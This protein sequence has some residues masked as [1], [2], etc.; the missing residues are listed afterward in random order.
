MLPSWQWKGTSGCY[1]DKW[2]TVQTAG[3]LKYF[4]S[5]E[6]ISVKLFWIIP[7]FTVTNWQ[8]SSFFASNN[9]HAILSFLIYITVLHSIVS[10]TTTFHNKQSIIFPVSV[11]WMDTNERNSDTGR[12]REDSGA[13]EG[14]TV[15]LI[16]RWL[17]VQFQIIQNLVLLFWFIKYDTQNMRL[18]NTAIKWI[19]ILYQYNIKIYFSNKNSTITLW[20]GLSCRNHAPA[21]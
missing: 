8:C 3:Q 7:N 16:D 2:R 21:H 9:C 12:V 1:N 5:Q 17:T 19:Y 15:T 6:L 10:R 13:I 20:G 14:S 18:K 11:I 4:H